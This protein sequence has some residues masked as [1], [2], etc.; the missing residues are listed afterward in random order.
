[1]SANWRH[2]AGFGSYLLY[3]QRTTRVF[4]VAVLCNL[5]VKRDFNV[6]DV[7]NKVHVAKL[8]L[9]FYLEK[10]EVMVSILSVFEIN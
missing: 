2:S 4:V 7:R 8:S 6:C 5:Y 1:M 9:L 3:E 10:M